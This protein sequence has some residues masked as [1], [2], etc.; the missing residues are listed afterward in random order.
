MYLLAQHKTIFEYN[1]AQTDTKYESECDLTIKAKLLDVYCKYFG[2]EFPFY[3]DTALYYEDAFCYN[4]PS[5]WKYIHQPALPDRGLVTQRFDLLP[6][7]VTGFLSD[8]NTVVH[9][10]IWLWSKRILIGNEWPVCRLTL[11]T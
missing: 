3:N 2:E 10:I 8:F 6:V 11:S 5:V 4:G 1:D 9:V 7:L